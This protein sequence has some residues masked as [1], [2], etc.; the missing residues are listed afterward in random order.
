MHAGICKLNRKKRSDVVDQPAYRFALS[1]LSRPMKA[2]ALVTIAA[3]LL[4]SATLNAQGQESRNTYFPVW[5]YHSSNTNI[6]GLSLG[7]ATPGF[8]SQDNVRNT[9]SYGIKVELIGWGFVSPLFPES[10]VAKSS[11]EFATL[12]EDPLSENIYGLSISLSGTFCDCKTVGVSVGGVGQYNFQVDGLSISPI[13]LVQVHNGVQIAMA[14]FA[15]RM[16]GFQIGLRNESHNAT[17]VQIGLFNYSDNLK[18][19]QIGLW[20]VNH[21]R[22][23]PVVNWGF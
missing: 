23:S 19:L 6:L 17:G 13:N 16:R 12:N 21:E 9:N 22:I 3:L 14:S 20:N 8:P 18:G 7:F 4:G 1:L 11:Q 5:S 2:H 10:P 15:Y